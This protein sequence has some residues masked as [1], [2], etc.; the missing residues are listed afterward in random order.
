MIVGT[1]VMEDGVCAVKVSVEVYR[2][3]SVVEEI[4]YVPV[5]Y[6]CLWP[7]VRGGYD[8]FGLV[9]VEFDGHKV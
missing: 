9:G 5:R 8:Y 1:E 2:D 6:P 3:M 7:R 4:D